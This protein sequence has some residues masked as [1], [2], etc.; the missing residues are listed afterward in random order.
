MICGTLSPIGIC[1]KQY[2]SIYL[3][4]KPVLNK[5][6]DTDFRVLAFGAA[7]TIQSTALRGHPRPYFKWYRQRIG[8]CASSCKPDDRK[9]RRV[10][11]SVINPSAHTP[12]RISRLFLPPS[13]AGYYFRCVAENA[14]GRDDVVYQV[15]RMGK[16]TSRPGRC[17]E[18]KPNGSIPGR[19]H[20]ASHCPLPPRRD[21]VPWL[22]IVS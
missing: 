7:T 16:N 9:W 20:L 2:I 18:L 1:F 10:P 13:K 14:L 8:F 17:V 19:R 6:N 12:S 11:R 22:H 3:V 21:I 5:K 4:E 15:H